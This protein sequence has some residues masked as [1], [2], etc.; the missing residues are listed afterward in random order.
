MYIFYSRECQLWSGDP[1]QLR[2]LFN[3]WKTVECSEWVY[4]IRLLSFKKRY[5]LIHNCQTWFWANFL[6]ESGSSSRQMKTFPF[7][8]PPLVRFTKPP[9]IW[10]LVWSLLL[11]QI[12]I[13]EAIWMI[14]KANYHFDANF[15]SELWIW[16]SM[17]FAVSVE[18]FPTFRGP[19]PIIVPLSLDSAAD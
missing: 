7:M 14:L 2:Q 3:I 13:L 18:T 19:G 9:W 10:P 12:V 15:H 11:R 6:P 8:L 4:V 17:L 5:F 16:G 1:D